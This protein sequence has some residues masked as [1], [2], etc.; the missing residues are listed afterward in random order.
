MQLQFIGSGVAFGS[1]G[2]FNTCF[3]ITGEKV[4]FLI[5][6][7]ASS[8][9]SLKANSINLNSITTIL[10]THFHADHFGGIPFLML[11]AQFFSKRTQPLTI[12]GP[13]GLNNHFELSM[14]TYFPGSS[15]TKPRF[16]LNLTELEK[17][18]KTMVGELKVTPFEVNHGNP[19]GPYL[20]YRIRAEDRIIA[21]TGDTEWT[22]NIIKAG[23]EADLLIAEAY[24]YSKKVK[25]HL[26]YNTLEKHLP[27][28]KPKRL[29]LTHLSD[30]MLS[31]SSSIPHEVAKDGKII[32][33]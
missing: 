5:D 26:D 6:C 7:G 9:I 30:D 28:I 10:C 29:I 17:N 2:R 16:E 12:V 13:P 14:E 22:N 24:F 8:L 21:Y 31:R 3:H 18:K 15:E 27:L 25:L 4:N 23:Y 32:E 1:G 11:D 19:G 33:L 20:A